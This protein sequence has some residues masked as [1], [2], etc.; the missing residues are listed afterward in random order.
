MTFSDRTNVTQNFFTNKNFWGSQII[1]MCIISLNVYYN[2][3]L[4]W[5][6]FKIII[7]SLILNKNKPIAR[8]HKL[9]LYENNYNFQ[10]KIILIGRIMALFYIF[11]NFSNVKLNGR[12]LNFLVSVCNL[13]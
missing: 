1:F 2:R 11:A 3:I 9:Q 13:L 6:M 4:K 7:F 12:Q 5:E 8:S 10:N